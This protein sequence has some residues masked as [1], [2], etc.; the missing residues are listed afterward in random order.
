MLLE[1]FDIE[2]KSEAEAVKAIEVG[3]GHVDELMS[4]LDWS[5]W[6]RCEPACSLGPGVHQENPV[7]S[8]HA[9]SCFFYFPQ[10]QKATVPESSAYFKQELPSTFSVTFYLYF[11]FSVTFY[12]YF[13]FFFTF[14][15]RCYWNTRTSYF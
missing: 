2:E 1:F 13:T 3:R 4:W 12:P 6:V 8:F 9:F 7:F 14:G 11:T 15:M 5:V 10:V